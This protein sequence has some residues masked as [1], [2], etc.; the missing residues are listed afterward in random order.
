MIRTYCIGSR[1]PR[2]SASLLGEPIAKG[3]GFEFDAHSILD[4]NYWTCLEYKRRQHRAELVNRRGIITIQHHIA[5]PVAHSN[6]KQLD[7]EISWSLPLGKN[8][9]NPLLCV[10][11]FNW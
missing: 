6:D 8:L 5:A 9:Q 7:L 11:V 1:I 3:N 4:G 2:R 10:L